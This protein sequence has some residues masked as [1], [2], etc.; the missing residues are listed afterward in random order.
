MNKVG[1]IFTT[2]SDKYGLHRSII[3]EICAHPFRFSSRKIANPNDEKAMMMHYLGKFRIKRR[4]SGKKHEWC[5]G[6]EKIKEARRLNKS[7]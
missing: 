1:D 2:L 6:L 7:K 3:M 4:Y 5:D